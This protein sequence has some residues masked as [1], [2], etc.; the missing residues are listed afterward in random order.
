MKKILLI[1]LCFPMIGIGQCIKGDCENGCN[2]IAEYTT[3]NG[4]TAKYEG[5]FKNS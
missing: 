3:Q 1:L 2:A 4:R 5:C